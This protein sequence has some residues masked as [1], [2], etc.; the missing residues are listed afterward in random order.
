MAV[1][2]QLKIPSKDSGSVKNACGGEALGVEPPL[3]LFAHG[4]GIF[5]AMFYPQRNFDQHG[6]G[7]P[8]SPV[9][10]GFSNVVKG[11]SLRRDGAA[12]QRKAGEFGMLLPLQQAALGVITDGTEEMVIA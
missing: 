7:E 6:R 5:G 8:L 12:E 10:K 9:F 1:G 11:K 2:I 4:V 3:K